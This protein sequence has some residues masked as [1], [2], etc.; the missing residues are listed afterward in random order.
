MGAGSGEGKEVEVLP[1]FLAPLLS[2]YGRVEVAEKLSF[3]F[4]F[5]G[6]AYEPDDHTLYPRSAKFRGA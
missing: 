1:L 5:V 3:D 4:R 2:E 6:G